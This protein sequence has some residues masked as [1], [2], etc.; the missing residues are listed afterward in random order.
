MSGSTDTL[1]IIALV[2]TG[3]FFLVSVF[4]LFSHQ[5]MKKMQERFNEIVRAV[6]EDGVQKIFTLQAEIDA[7]QKQITE[8]KGSV[9]KLQVSNKQLEERNLEILQENKTALDKALKAE[10][11]Q[12]QKEDLFAVYIHDIRNPA[13]VIKS[14]AEMMSGADHSIRDEKEMISKLHHSS[15]KIIQ[16]STEISEF[17]ASENVQRSLNSEISSLNSIAKQVYEE[18]KVKADRKSIPVFLK[19]HPQIPDLPLDKKRINEAMGNL[20]DNAIKFSQSGSP[21][22]LV[23]RKDFRFVYFEVADKGPGLSEDE[24]KKAFQKGQKLTPRPTAGE[25]STGLG[26]W[27]VRKIA[28]EHRGFAFVRSELGKGASFGFCIPWKPEEQ[29][30]VKEKEQ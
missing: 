27:I 19:L 29:T 18:M 6:G 2:V 24:M 8:L 21:I 20:L 14:I 4:L 15:D 22:E 7:Q 5:K 26:L 23:T 17:I 11:N 10:Q 25:T 16:Y 3:A 1:I 28:Y 13:G 30:T 9:E 12:K